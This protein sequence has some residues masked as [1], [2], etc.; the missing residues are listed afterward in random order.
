MTKKDFIQRY[1]IANAEPV[2]PSKRALPAEAFSSAIVEFM[3]K[4]FVGAVRI[5]CD[6]I[7]AQSISVC[8]EYVAH[9]FK[10]LLT[11]VYGRVLLN[12]NIH[13]DGEGLHINVSADGALPISDVEMCSLIRLARNGGF[14]I[15]PASDSIRLSVGFS[16]TAPRRVYAVT[17][18][19]GRRVMLGKLIEIFCHGELLDP[20]P[21]PPQP[22]PEPIK[23]RPLRKKTKK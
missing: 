12:I 21:P 17:I 15:Y 7:S 2:D 8:A 23:K 9:F 1:S 4:R 18:M 19:D 10:T 20:D 11:D 13:S 3:E 14:E 16:P 22:M 5:E 6:N